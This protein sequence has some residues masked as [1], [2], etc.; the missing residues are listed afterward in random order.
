MKPHDVV[1]ELM[2]MRRKVV[3]E[4]PHVGCVPL[5]SAG[6]QEYKC[7]C[8]KLSLNAALLRAEID[9]RNSLGMEPF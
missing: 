3:R 1:N 6:P 2:E 9:V 8:Y 7:R 4:M 5:V